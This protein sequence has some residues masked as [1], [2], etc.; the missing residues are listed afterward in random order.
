VFTLISPGNGYRTVFRWKAPATILYCLTI[1]ERSIKSKLLAIILLPSLGPAVAFGGQVDPR[2]DGRWVGVET[3]K[4]NDGHFEL[5]GK[6]PQISTRI[7]IADSGQLFGVLAGFAPGRYIISD[8]S[9]GNAIMVHS[10]LRNCKFV[11]S[12]D[13]NTLKEDGLVTIYTNLGLAGCQ[14]WATFHRVGK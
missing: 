8:K 4:Y 10:S 9:H 2:F 7:G 14:V 12:A 13:G 5:E 11:L 3:F 6:A 1:I